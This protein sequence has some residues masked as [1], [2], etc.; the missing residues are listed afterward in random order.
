MEQTLQIGIFGDSISKGIVLDAETHRYSSLKKEITEWI[1]PSTALHNFSVM[2]S[3][4]QKGLS[5]ITHHT[6][7]LASYQN[8]FL[9][10]GG[11]DCDFD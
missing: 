7:Q 2:G 10:F 1:S 8:V 5:I 9:E 4:I 6:D 3:T 11:N